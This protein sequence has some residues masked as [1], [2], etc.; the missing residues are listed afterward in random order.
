MAKK[1]EDCHNW[2]KAVNHQAKNH[3]KVAVTFQTHPVKHGFKSPR[4]TEAT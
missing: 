1:S 2:H 4:Q 3:L